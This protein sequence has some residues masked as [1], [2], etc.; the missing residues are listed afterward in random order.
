MQVILTHEESEEIFYNILCNAVSTGYM[1]GYG[2]DLKYS[3]KAYQQAK[4]NLVASGKEVGDICYEDV[5]MQI[6][7][8]GGAL[9]F[10]DTECDGE[11]TRKVKLSD[12]HEKVQRA[13]FRSLMEM[14]NQEDDAGTAD[15]IL[16]HVLY[17]E[18][19]FG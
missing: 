15:V 2:L 13:P 5:L 6:L 7:Q 16:Q 1:N 12:I 17:G 10:V 18:T 3:E 8:D 9:T 14:V 19:I 11:Y 4:Q